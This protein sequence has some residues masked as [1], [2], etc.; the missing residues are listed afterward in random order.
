MRFALL[1]L[2][3]FAGIARAQSAEEMLSSCRGIESAQ[4]RDGNITIPQ[5]FESGRC[6]G[7]FA[8]IQRLTSF[9]D[10]DGHR[11]LHICTPGGKTLTEFVAI[12]SEYVRRNPKTRS[13]DFMR[14]ALNSL[15]EAFPCSDGQ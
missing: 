14:T 8:T 5:T 7:T 10:P 9:T 4:L 6:W 2:F 3:A 12:F 15:A 13:D 1:A 11:M